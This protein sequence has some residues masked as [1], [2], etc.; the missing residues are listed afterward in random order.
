[1]DLGGLIKKIE[2]QARIMKTK[3]GME[4]KFCKF[5]ATF[6]SDVMNDE[7]GKSLLEK[8]GLETTRM[9][10]LF[11][12]SS[13]FD[14]KDPLLIIS[15]EHNKIGTIVYANSSIYPLLKLNNPSDLIGVNITSFIAP[16]FNEVF[17]KF[18][19]RLLIFRNSTDSKINNL[20]LI[21]N[22]K[23]CIE[24]FMN[25]EITNHNFLPF[26]VVTLKSIKTENNIILYSLPGQI[27]AKS[28]KIQEIFPN[29][30]YSIQ[31][32]PNI[33][34]YLDYN[35][36]EKIFFY[37]EQINCC[38]KVLKLCIEDK[39]IRI[40]YVIKSSEDNTEDVHLFNKGVKTLDFEETSQFVEKNFK[41]SKENELE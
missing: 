33:D 8:F 21:T 10:L 34:K 7:R 11:R 17:K 18:L 25:I 36:F 23:Y 41:N 22:E 16:P 30:S 6:L 4:R 26:F 31:G 9:S 1:M 12:E 24:V 32:I 15:G 14:S 19:A 5:Y 20:F 37:S 3:F 28:E 38:M 40:L 29:L 35:D 39:N 27:Y 13:D 2:E